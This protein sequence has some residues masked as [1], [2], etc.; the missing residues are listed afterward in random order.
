MPSK[1]DMTL[2]D[3]GT[4]L[5]SHYAALLD[6]VPDAVVIHGEGR[7]LHVNRATLVLIGASCPEQLIGRNPI[8]LVHPDDRAVVAERVRRIQMEGERAD[9][10][11]ERLVRLDGT[12]IDVETTAVPIRYHGRPALQAVLR[13][14]SKR[15][16]AEQ[17]L[18]ASEERFRYLTETIPEVFWVLEPHN[19]NPWYVSPAGERIYGISAK[20][21]RERPQATLECIHPDDQPRVLPIMLGRFREPYDLEYRIIRPDGQIRWLRSRSFPT[22]DDN[23]E[24]IRIAGFTEDITVCKDAEQRL[25]KSEASLANAQHVAQLSSWEFDLTDPEFDRNPLRWSDEVFRIFGYEPGSFEPTSEAFFACVHAEDRARV[26]EAARRAFDDREPY[27]VEHRIVRPDGSERIVHERSRVYYEE[28]SGRPLRMV[29]TVQ[30]VTERARTEERLRRSEEQYRLLFDANPHAMWVLALSTLRFLAVND[31]AVQQYG[32]SRD[33]FLAMTICDI[34]SPEEVPALLEG[35]TQAEQG[36]P[37]SRVARHHKKNGDLIDVEIT[38]H[39]ITFQG[40]PGRVEQASDVTERERVKRALEASERKFRE[41]FDSSLDGITINRWEDGA[42]VEVNR[43][44]ERLTGFSRAEL[45]GHTQGKLNLWA[46]REAYKR[47]LYWLERD[48][49]VRS[50]QAEL[51]RRDGTTAWS[52]FSALRIDIGG[53]LCVVGFA[54]D[55]SHLKQTERALS[56]TRERLETIFDSL[57]RVFWSV[58]VL[59]AKVVY[60]S[61]AC[62]EIYG[63]PPERFAKRPTLWRDVILP[64]DRPIADSADKKVRGGEAVTVQYRILRRGGDVR[65]IE[66]HMKPSLNEFGTVTRIDGIGADISQ[67]R[68]AEEELSRAKDAALESTRLKSAFLANMSHEIRTPLNVI[69]GFNSFVAQHLEEVGDHSQDEYFDAIQRASRRLLGTIHGILD[70]SKIE[71]RGFEVRPALVDLGQ[72][73][74]RRVEDMHSFAEKKRIELRAEIDADDAVVLFDEYCLSQALAHLLDNAVKFTAEGS[75]CVRLYRDEDAVPVIEVEDTGVGIDEA[76]LSRLWEPFV[77][78]D[79]GY[80][81]RFEGSGLGLTLAKKYLEMNGASLTVKSRKGKGS[82]FRIRL[83]GTAGRTSGAEG[84]ERVDREG[85]D[86]A[87]P[88]PRPTVLVVEDDEDSQHYMS[89]LLGRRFEVLHASDG[90]DFRQCL[91]ENAGRIELILMDLSLRGS[92]DG[93]ALTRVLRSD[94][95][96]RHIP[97]IAVTAHALDRDRE[98]VFRA[99]CDDYVAKPIVPEDLMSRMSAAL[100]RRRAAASSR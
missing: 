31:A 79:A 45:L 57:D 7:I 52:L 21:F 63:Y 65:W 40:A 49:L 95:R 32:Y 10:V 28:H 64:E 87:L 76:F 2:P 36:I 1:P 91:G 84:G 78:E 5:G 100:R 15:K 88:A 12:V 50:Q 71:T 86:G 38:F 82:S 93:L 20:R 59:A 92:E 69:L 80:T 70:L 85:G 30:D 33:E 22:L 98:N 35:L 66:A 77:Q 54:R 18:R 4:G 26:R 60:V 67:R 3:L 90:E 51:R 55:I 94:R 96:W 99:G 23:G 14:I 34:R 48:G 19:P 61:R 24:L 47:M 16:Q 42:C 25:R 62:E 17:A 39:D 56:E 75:V 8:D 6:L 46:D 27:S 41:I 29:G 83:V 68:R 43:E 73:V 72:L 58:D 74:R 13:D 89:R 44:F 9:L 11:E 81:R 53:T 37:V 97:V